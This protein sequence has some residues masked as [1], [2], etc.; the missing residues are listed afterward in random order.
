[1]TRQPCDKLIALLRF[2]GSDRPRWYC[3]RQLQAYFTAA[4]YNLEEPEPTAVFSSK[5]S[6]VSRTMM[7]P[8]TGG[9]VYF[10]ISKKLV[11]L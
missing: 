2:D 3:D 5:N 10:A 4:G 1:M 8:S 9:G 6:R 7:M 11:G